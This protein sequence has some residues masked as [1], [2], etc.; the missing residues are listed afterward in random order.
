MEYRRDWIDAYGSTE[1]KEA[2]FIITGGNY[3]KEGKNET[4]PIKINES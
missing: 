3:S 4:V 2:L 1:L